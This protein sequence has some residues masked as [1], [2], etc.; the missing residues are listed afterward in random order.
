MTLL[1]KKLLLASLPLLA[2]VMPVYATGNGDNDNE[3][4]RSVV[5]EPGDYGSRF[6]RIPAIVT[7]DDGTL[8]SVADKRINNI[9]DLPNDIDVVCRRSTDGGRSWSEYITVARH[10][11]IGGYGDPAL[12]CDRN[13]GD[14]IVISTHGQGLWLPTPGEI[15]VSR[16]SD[17]GLTWMPPVSINDQI[18][19]CD[20]D[21]SQP[22]KC[23]SAFASSGR[24]VQLSD[25]RI[26]FVLVTRREGVEQF[27]CYAV[28]SD[29]GGH[30]WHVSATPTTTD[31]DESKIAQTADGTLITSIRDRRRM[32]RLFSRSTDNGVTWSSPRQIVTLPDP[33]CNGDFIRYTHD[34]HDL[35]LHSLPTGGSRH[36]VTI[37]VSRDNGATWTPTRRVARGASAYSSMTVLPDGSVGILTE[38][39]ANP[40]DPAVND[41]YRICYTRI[42]AS[43]IVGHRK[44]AH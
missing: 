7:L 43:E 19:T 27:T 40:D 25:G 26:M 6:Y 15:C 20:P 37:F 10:D 30:T 11:S 18:L 39:A 1:P 21:G 17:G 5:Y 3:V 42:P 41:G 2:A 36:N 16:S 8:V 9:A 12:V 31:G 44:A 4:I 13:S 23:N 38:E 22:I 33:A 35:L 29:D 32:C 14:L 28:Y 24:A 34:G